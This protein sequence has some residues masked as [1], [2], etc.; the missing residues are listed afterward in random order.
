MS[1]EWCDVPYSHTYK[2]TFKSI[3]DP[4]SK[5][6]FPQFVAEMVLFNRERYIKD[7]EKFPRGKG[8]STG[9]S[10]QIRRLVQQAT[11]ICNFFP[12]VENDSLVEISFRN[13][14]RNNR[15]FKIGQYR[16][17]RVTKEGKI[18]ITQDE[19]DTV[20]GILSEYNKLLKKRNMFAD[21]KPNK[22]NEMK[23]NVVSGYKKKAKKIDA[24]LE[25][26]KSL[27]NKE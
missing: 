14:F 25:L 24:I 9:K 7:F 21:L 16:K 18:N 11:V 3:F 8:W 4:Q 22:T 19:K 23:S 13:Y 20:K 10:G 1:I 2:K 6:T 5:I 26:E 17:T 15:V 27:L 12:S